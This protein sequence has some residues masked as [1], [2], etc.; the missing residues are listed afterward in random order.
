MSFP[1]AH[2]GASIPRSSFVATGTVVASSLPQSPH[3]A[4]NGSI[5]HLLA[6][7]SGSTPWTRS[8]LFRLKASRNRVLSARS[9]DLVLE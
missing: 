1:Q 8:H 9:Q 7:A 2:G 6:Q 3:G 5:P 4:V